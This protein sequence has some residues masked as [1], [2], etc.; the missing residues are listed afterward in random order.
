MDNLLFPLGHQTTTIAANGT[1]TPTIPLNANVALVQASELIFYRTDGT[2]ATTSNSQYLSPQEK[3]WFTSNLSLLRFL[4]DGLSSVIQIDYFQLIAE[5]VSGTV[6]VT[7][8]VDTRQLDCTT[9]SVEVC[10][11]TDPWSV[12]VTGVV[13]TRLLD[14]ATDSIEVCQGTV[15]W[16]VTI[17]NVIP[18]TGAIV[19]RELDCTTDSVEVCQGTFP[20][21]V[22]VSGT[23][24]TRLLDCASDS[25]SVCQLGPWDVG[26]TGTIDTR[27]LDC[28][29]DSIEVCQ[30]TVPWV[31][32]LLDQT[33]SVTG[34]VETR[35]LDC[36]TDSIEVCQGD[37]PWVVAVS[38]TV[39]VTGSVEVS[40]DIGNPLPVTYPVGTLN[41]GTQ[42]AVA[43]V[44]VSVAAANALRRAIILQNVG[45]ANVRVGT[46][47]VT[48]T[49]GFRL[50]PG[51]IVIL[52]HPY[53]P[54]NAI[55][56]IR[57]GAVSSTVLAQEIT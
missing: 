28:S 9:D 37:I 17:D 3:K 30:G 38:G 33:V 4:A 48:T 57:E 8:V 27:L 54:T 14:C 2:T 44:A 16:V 39:P 18:V 11:G 26:V 24:D 45:L 42:T 20:W 51:Q 13:D 55:F 1:L 35:F 19:N 46:T 52:E 23:I 50:V 25:I 40:N 47:G 32:D 43:A 5:P 15:P 56:A 22:A 21:D 31:V 41:N 49:T 53:V 12:A 6:G 7:G 29:T 36:G 10:Q 34:V